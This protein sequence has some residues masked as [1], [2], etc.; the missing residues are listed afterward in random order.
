MDAAF[1]N[2]IRQVTFMNTKN[3]IKKR[4]RNIKNII[5]KENESIKNHIIINNMI[6][7]KNKKMNLLLIIYLFFILFQISVQ[8]KDTRNLNSLNEITVIIKG[9]N[10]YA[11]IISGNSFPNSVTINGENNDP[12]ATYVLLTEPENTV[13][14]SWNSPLTSTE[15][16]F[17]NVENILSIDLSKFD[18]S[19][20]QKTA[21]MFMN[22]KNLKSINFNNFN[23]SSVGDMSYMFDS[24]VS[25][26]SLD[27]SSFNTGSTT[28]MRN[29]FSNCQSLVSL[30]LSNFNTNELIDVGGM[31]YNA[32]SLISLDLSNFNTSN[33]RLVDGMFAYCN[34]LVYVN[35]N[36]F[37]DE[38]PI[39]DGNNFFNNAPSNIIYCIDKTKAATIA[40]SIESMNSNNDCENI[41][42]SGSSKIITEKKTCIDDCK[43]DDTYIY[44][45]NNVCYDSIQNGVGTEAF[46]D[47]Y[48]E[49]NENTENSHYTDYISNT[50]ITEKINNEISQ[51]IEKTDEITSKITDKLEN[52]ESTNIIENDESTNIKTKIIVENDEST[53]IFENDES[54]MVVTNIIEDKTDI[55]DDY[56]QIFKNFSSKSFFQESKQINI[57]SPAQKDE[58]IKNIKED[59][60]N[61]NLNSLLKDVIE[62]SKQDLIAIDN[63]I[64]YQI[65]T[66]EN[67]QNNSYA[68]ISTVNLGGCEQKLKDIYH[69][70]NSLPLIILKVDYYMEGLL[71]P[72]IGYEVYHPTNKSQLDLNYCKDNYV[73]L[74]IPV[75]INEDNLFKHDPNS[76]YYNDECNTYTTEN[77]TD[78]L[79]NDRQNEYIYNNLSL[80]E[81]NCS[82]NGYEKNTKKASCECET[83]PAI[84][85]I[86]DIIKNE[87]ILSNNF[88]STDDT[89][90]NI[91]TM[92]CISTLFSKEGLLTNIASYILLFSFTFFSISL[93]IFYK[94]GY[95]LFEDK[96][97]ELIELKTKKMANNINIYSKKGRKAL[98]K[99]KKKKKNNSS[100]TKK[101]PKNIIKK[102]NNKEMHQ[103]TSKLQ[104]KSID[105]KLNLK[106]CK[107]KKLK[108][109]KNKKINDK[110]ND[111]NND[112]DNALKMIKYKYCEL[113]SFDYEK[114]LKYDYR[115]FSQYYLSLLISK[116][117][118]L[119]SFYPIKDYNI[120]VIKVSLLFLSFDIHFFINALFFNDSVIHQ[121]YEDNGKYNFSFFFPKIIISFIISYAIIGFIRYF[122]LSERY[123][124]KMKNVEDKNTLIKI[125]SKSKKCLNIKYAIFYTLCFI[126]LILF[127]FYL[128]SFCAVFQ[129][130]QIFLL[131]NAL[132][133]FAISIFLPLI[134]NLIP[135]FIRIHSFKAKSQFFYKFSIILQL[136]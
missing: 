56:S 70:N 107:K 73:K 108:L 72:V 53:N 88:N 25:L 29:M 31:F 26:V 132:I 7:Y 66:T 76:D 116:H 67:Q 82:F 78:I 134:Y 71:I 37:G 42:F 125:V 118:I 21:R 18:T 120:K 100:P 133:S 93:V 58:I 136:F 20:L 5:I 14:F 98:K 105:I 102:Y 64:I 59:L 123:I 4:K 17:Y 46:S 111:K 104:I 9:T 57:E 95:N 79:I 61:G 3:N 32:F 99:S 106:K 11:A 60:I 97:N 15:G 28:S 47:D 121:I 10:E 131:E 36:S 96:I 81:N 135:S 52:N 50:E 23:T 129:N 16:M 109:N 35:M 2:K 22:C 6:Y 126:F 33:L 27:L 30:D 80:C 13:V 114:A 45:Y 49:V 91:V 92:K 87:D 117:V 103:S 12:G 51:D 113:N 75:S 77:G 128:S 68:N 89:S 69:I 115:T 63:D 48:S 130:S 34:S 112:N 86:S 90:L 24:C 40:D 54:T 65:T 43:N 44:E 122:S 38:I 85:L 84:G 83:K 127:W 39:S 119:F 1:N 62:G 8:K 94:C 101:K 74:K 19:Q 110:S 55:K 124:I 41:C